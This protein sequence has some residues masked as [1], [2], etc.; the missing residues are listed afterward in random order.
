V[1]VSAAGAS[2]PHA[3]V[4]QQILSGVADA[5]IPF[6]DL[7]RL[8]LTLGFEMRTKGSHYVFWE[9]RSKGIYEMA[10]NKDGQDVQDL[11]H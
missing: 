11:Y 4:L 7:C 5:N 10:F 1:E 8:R 3:N 6:A 9:K 2:Q